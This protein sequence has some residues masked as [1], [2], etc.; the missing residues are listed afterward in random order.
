MTLDNL[1]G[2]FP[3]WTQLPFSGIPGGDGHFSKDPISNLEVLVLNP[4]V[5]VFGRFLLKNNHY[6]L[7]SIPLLLQQVQVQPQSFFIQFWIIVFNLVAK[8]P[9]LHKYH[10]FSF[11]HQSKRCFF[12]RSLGGCPVGPQY[13]QEK[14]Y[15]S[16][17]LVFKLLL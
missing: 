10:S 7:S 13:L 5:E 1:V 2:P 12:G 16:T 15:L 11:V 8:R 6:Y 17:F 3:C 4:F 9:Y 14:L